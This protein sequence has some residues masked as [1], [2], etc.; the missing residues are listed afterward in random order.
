[1]KF[2][3]R[4]KDNIEL[5]SQTELSCQNH[6]PNEFLDVF[7]QKFR[8][9]KNSKRTL[10]VL[11]TPVIALPFDAQMKMILNWASNCE[12][13][14]VCLANMHMLIEA[15]WH[16]EFAHILK[17]AD[18][19]TPHG[20]LLVWIIRLMTAQQYNRVAPM[21]ILWFLCKQAPQ[22]NISVF[23]LGAKATVLEKLRTKLQQKFPNLKI[24]GISPLPLRSLT[25]AEDDAI[26]QKINVSG[27]TLVFVILK[28]PKQEYWMHQHKG[29]IQAVMIGL[30]A[31]LPLDPSGAL[32]QARE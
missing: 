11:G 12:S 19:V 24:A 29:K 7:K 22:H 10:N 28:Y 17:S 18:I 15:Y 6:F 4:K 5:P 27:A 20:I 31:V 2:S 9:I 26:I 16:P 32:G 14:V 3:L 8:T 1:M 23:F 30:G 21:D 25:A 13:K